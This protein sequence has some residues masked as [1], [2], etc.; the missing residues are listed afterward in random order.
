MP[1]RPICSTIRYEPSVAPGLKLSLF[2][3]PPPSPARHDPLS[4]MNDQIE[5]T[6]A[7]SYPI[8]DNERR[9]NNDRQRTCQ[10]SRGARL[11]L[12]S[13][14]EQVAQHHPDQDRQH[15]GAPRESPD[16]RPHAVAHRVPAAPQGDGLF[17]HEQKRDTDSGRGDQRQDR[18]GTQV[19]VCP[20]PGDVR[21]RA[22]PQRKCP[23]RMPTT[24][25]TMNAHA[26]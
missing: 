25:A 18:L 8:R 2:L 10:K 26:G 1:P 6:Y 5:P 19:H 4:S 14:P 17:E 13:R 12:R 9:R 22:G 7:L 11:A 23:S 24:T 3:L 21:P 15:V 20:P 16:K